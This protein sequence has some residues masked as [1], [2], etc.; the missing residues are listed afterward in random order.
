MNIGWNI[1]CSRTD[2][3]TADSYSTRWRAAPPTDAEHLGLYGNLTQTWMYWHT[4][5]I[6]RA[7][8]NPEAK[9]TRRYVLDCLNYVDKIVGSPNQGQFKFQSVQRSDPSTSLIGCIK[10]QLICSERRCSALAF[11]Y[12]SK[13]PDLHRFRIGWSFMFRK[14][15]HKALD[16]WLVL[17]SAFLVKQRSA[18]AAALAGIN[19]QGE[20]APQTG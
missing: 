1:A 18:L 3:T 6:A 7:T 19:N 4:R 16:Q 5:A 12:C 14:P 2:T 20:F 9:V 17:A 10:H 15:F 13:W 11:I 8:G